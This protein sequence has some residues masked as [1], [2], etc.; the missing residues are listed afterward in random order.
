MDHCEESEAE[1][2]RKQLHSF[3]TELLNGDDI[4]KKTSPYLLAML[5]DLEREEA[6]KNGDKTKLDSAIKV[7]ITILFIY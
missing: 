5:L 4:N 7:K 3:C 6:L 2:L 1:P